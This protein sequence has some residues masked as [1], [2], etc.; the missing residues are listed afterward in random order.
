MI[1]KIDIKATGENIKAL[2]D[3]TGVT[4]TE[5]KEWCGFTTVMPIYHWIHGRNLPSLDSL[6]ILACMFG[7]K[8]DDIIVLEVG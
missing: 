8:M 7:C 6:A 1:P 2:M 3:S 5:I 4:P